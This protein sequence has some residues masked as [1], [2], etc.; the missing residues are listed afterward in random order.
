MYGPSFAKAKVGIA[1]N[2]II[3]AIILFLIFIIFPF[4]FLIIKEALKVGGGLKITI[5]SNENYY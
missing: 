1:I 5:I 2:E 3:N 4:I